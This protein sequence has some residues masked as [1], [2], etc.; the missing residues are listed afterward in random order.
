MPQKDRLV[1]QALDFL[2]NEKH[3]ANLQD[4]IYSMLS[5]CV[6]RDDIKVGYGI[7]REE[8]MCRTFRTCQHTLCFC[9]T[10][11]ISRTLGLRPTN[12]PTIAGYL[13]NFGIFKEAQG[14]FGQGCN[15]HLPRSWLVGYSQFVCLEKLCGSM[16]I[17]PFTRP[18]RWKKLQV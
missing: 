3:Y 1:T 17:V 15:Y 9:S 16:D 13:I 12:L 11:M 4:R 2:G 14:Y 5:L 7:T 10:T 18:L 6:E 8:L